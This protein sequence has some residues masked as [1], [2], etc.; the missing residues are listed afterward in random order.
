MPNLYDLSNEFLT[1]QSQL[2]E[3]DLDQET[4]DNTLESYQVTI[5]EKA[6]N[7]V[8]YIKNL[9]A[10]AEAR[11]AE[12]NRLTELAS[13]DLKKAEN[14]MNYLDSAMKM[15]GKKQLTAG[16]FELKYRRGS[17]VVEV[18]ESLLPQDYFVPQPPKAMGKTELKKLI[19]DGVEIPG[20]NLV[21]NADKLAVK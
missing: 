17:E 14:L 2:E 8:K 15:L 19:K 6:E 11:K 16:V 7:I 4:L 18:N 5:E 21:R 12:A 3:L 9:E 10:M 13:K 1:I 20:V